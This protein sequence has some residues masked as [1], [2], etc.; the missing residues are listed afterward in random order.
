[1]SREQNIITALD[2]GSETI[3]GMVAQK[4]K[5]RKEIE[6]LSLITVPSEGIRKGVVIDMEAVSEKVYQVI[7]KMRAEVKPYKIKKAYINIGDSRVEAKK[8]RGAVAISRADQKVSAEDQERVLEE[9]KNIGFSYDHSNREVIDALAIEFSVD[10][11]SGLKDVEGM[12]GIKLE[13]EALVICVFSPYLKRLIDAV[14]GGEAEIA[15]IIP[16]PILAAEAV[17]T[18]QQ[19]E[20]GVVVVDIGAQV[21]SIA[22]YEE[23]CLIHL[24]VL[25]V[26]SANISRDIAIAL[27]TDIEIAEQIK[28]KF[29]SHIFQN[30]RKKEKINIKDKEDFVFDSAKMVKAGRARVAEIFRLVQKELKKISRH[31]SLPAGLVLTGGGANLSGITKFAKKELKLPVMQGVP[32][33]FIGIEEDPCLSVLCGAIIKG[34]QEQEKNGS[35][36]GLNIFS[37]IKKFFRVFVP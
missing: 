6:V 8:G 30:K 14:I 12:K 4:R 2:I 31:D 24:A 19:K 37:R 17:L 25:P 33:G 34:F 26:G 9:A 28:R 1:M 3:K 23:K 11:E 35:T 7:T 27:Q 13:A 5:D 16:S 18:P 32:H 15:E 21:T 20:L 22:V 36:G 29:G 10:G